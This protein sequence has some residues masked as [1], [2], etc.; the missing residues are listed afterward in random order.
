MNDET[1]KEM[2]R[3]TLINCVFPDDVPVLGVWEIVGYNK[4][5]EVFLERMGTMIKVKWENLSIESER[6][7]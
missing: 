1:K 7:S 4:K 5:G 6:R 3:A 2:G